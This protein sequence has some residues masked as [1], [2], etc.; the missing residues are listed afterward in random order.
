MTIEW[1]VTTI[2]LIAILITLGY[3]WFIGYRG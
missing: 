3:W 1:I 2:L